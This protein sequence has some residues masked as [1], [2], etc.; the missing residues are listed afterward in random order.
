M[1]LI[2]WSENKSSAIPEMDAS[3]RKF[4][5]MV[6]AM[7]DAED[8]QLRL[9]FIRFHSHIER[10]FEQ[11]DQLMESCR[12]PDRKEHRSEHEQMLNEIRYLIQRIENG[13]YTLG[14]TYVRARLPQWFNA[15]V[16]T[17]DDNLAS[18]L[19]TNR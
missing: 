14:H 4:V 19:S 17:M 15:H 7:E 9:F 18:Y 5:D 1:P 13:L 11:E 10:F 6:N 16:A 8:S 3:R 2:Q 12:F